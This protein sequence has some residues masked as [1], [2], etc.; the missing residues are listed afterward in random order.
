M[1]RAILSLLIKESKIMHKEGWWLSTCRGWV[2]KWK[3]DEWPS[4]G[5]GGWAEGWVA[6]LRDGWLGRGMGG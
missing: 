2:A 5:V 3:G 4:R 6:K 1:M